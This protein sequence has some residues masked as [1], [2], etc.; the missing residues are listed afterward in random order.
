MAWLPLNDTH[1]PR[2]IVFQL[3]P[4]RVD[5][6]PRLYG[7]VMEPRQRNC[8]HKRAGW[9]RMGRSGAGREEERGGGRTGCCSYKLPFVRKDGGG[10]TH[11]R[12]RRRESGNLQS[13]CFF[14]GPLTSCVVALHT[15]LLMAEPVMLCCAAAI[16][17]VRDCPDMLLRRRWWWWWKRR[18]AA[19]STPGGG[20][21]GGRSKCL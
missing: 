16:R 4:E 8:Q 19:R 18:Q 11:A 6:R 21:R 12:Y 3:R 7:N 1:R 17:S 2:I 13:R 9:E 14:L 15:A 10:L 5:T 20:N